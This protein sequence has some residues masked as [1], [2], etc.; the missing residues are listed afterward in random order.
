[1]FATPSFRLTRQ[2]EGCSLL[3]SLL[4]RFPDAPGVRVKSGKCQWEGRRPNANPGQGKTICVEGGDWGAE[5]PITSRSTPLARQWDGWKGG[6]QLKPSWEA[7]IVCQKPFTGSCHAN[8]AQHGVGGWNVEAAR[9]PFDVEDKPSGGY[10][11]M[12]VGMGDIGET[13]EYTGEQECNPSGRFPSHLLV[14]DD[15]LGPEGSKYFSLDRWAAEHG[16]TEEGWVEAAEAGLV[17]VPKAGKKEKEEGL[18]GHPERE[19]GRDSL[20]AGI[21]RRNGSHLDASKLTKRKPRNHHPTVKPVRLMSYLIH[22]AC[23]KV[24]PEGRP[25]L[26]LD[27]FCGSG[28]TGVAA[29]KGGWDFIGIE[30]EPEYAE[31]ARARIA[32]AEAEAQAAAPRLL[33]VTA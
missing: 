25:G 7:I 16:I 9:V 26:I 18:E 12:K 8:V 3:A 27:P 32:H 20:A 24:T 28:T 21:D 11:G 15:A 23:P 13:Q 19:W 29:V 4:A 33:E 22:L 10:G 2:S 6:G 1:M 17:Q 14:S 31:I 5:I 30:M